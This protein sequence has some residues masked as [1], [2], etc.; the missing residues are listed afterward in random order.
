MCT[1]P[2]PTSTIYVDSAELL[3]DYMGSE[4]CARQGEIQLSKNFKTRYEEADVLLIDDVQY[5][6]GKKQTL[7]IVFQIFNKLTG[8]GRQV[9]LRPT[10][11]RRTSTSTSATRA[12]STPAA[13]SISN[14]RR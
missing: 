7:D 12:V 13:R 6:Q 4:C 1:R 10:A 3:S 8:Q 2:C 5:L 14:R 9:V 11:R